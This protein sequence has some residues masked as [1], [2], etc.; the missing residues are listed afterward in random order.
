MQPQNFFRRANAI[1]KIFG[2]DAIIS[3]TIDPGSITV[4]MTFTWGNIHKLGKL[5]FISDHGPDYLLFRR[6]QYWI[7]IHSPTPPF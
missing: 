4:R 2:E 5:L 6:G 7:F 3:M 1:T